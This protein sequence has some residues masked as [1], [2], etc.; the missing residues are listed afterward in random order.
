MPL[1]YWGRQH[2]DDCALMA[3][4]E[5]I[6]ELTGHKPSEEEVI[7]LAAAT[8]NSEGSGPIYTRPL[9]PKHPEANNGGIRRKDQL[10]VIKDL[11]V[12]LAHYGV[13]SVH[14]DDSIAANGGLPTRLDALES[15]LAAGKKVIVSL[16]GETIW[17]KPG[18]RTIH[19][20]D[21]VVIVVD[22]RAGTVHL[23]DSA[24]PHPDSRIPVA[25][26]EAA[27]KTSDHAM[28]IAG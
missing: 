17:N 10:P 24:T 13:E 20:H 9:D 14:T 2:Y 5:V 27:W 22:S 23:N 7:A 26:F 19:D 6:G 8:P 15:Y 18:D 21:V 1:N 28:V 25:I 12:L 4:A 11:P 16:N 3:V